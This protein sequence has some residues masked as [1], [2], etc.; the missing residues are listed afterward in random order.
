LWWSDWLEI[1]IAVV[2]WLAMSVTPSRRRLLQTLLLAPVVAGCTDDKPSRR[3]VDSPDVALRQAAIARERALIA[4]YRSA[5]APSTVLAAVAADHEAHLRALGAGPAEPSTSPAPSGAPTT[6][7]ALATEERRA[8]AAHAAAALDASPS[9][10]ALLA[11]LA[12]CEAS[13]VVALT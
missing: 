8:A 9:L 3:S 10:A 5:A 13:H 12:A 11:S 7:A 4:H 6:P 2:G 1:T